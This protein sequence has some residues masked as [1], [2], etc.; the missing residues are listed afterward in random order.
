LNG[1]LYLA[2]Q[3]ENPFHALLSGYLVAKANG[4]LVKLA[5]RFDLDPDTGRVQ[6]IFDNNPQLPF[7]KLHLEFFGGPHGPLTNPGCGTQ[8]VTSV[9]DG[10]NGAS[11][12]RTSQFT[13][14]RNCTVPQFNPTVAMGLQNPAAGSSSAF[15]LRITRSDADSELK[16][17]GTVLPPGLLAKITGVPRCS[18][19]QAAAGACPEGAQI[20]HVE[21]GSGSGPDPFFVQGGKVFLTD[22]YEGAPF[23]LDIAVPAVAGPFDLGL[24][25]VRAA[26][27]IDPTDA[28]ATVTADPMP[29][30]LQGIPLDVRD[31]RVTIDRPGFM[32]APTSCD[33]M[34]IAATLGSYAGDSV[35]VP[36][37]FQVGG[38]GDLPFSPKLAIA[39]GGGKSQ[40]TPGK[41][42]SL[43]ATYTQAAGQANT[44]AVK[45]ALP[46]SLALDPNNSQHVCDH[47]A[48][49]AVHGG[50][51]PC[52]ASTIVGTAT[53]VTPL[54]PN[55]LQAKVYLVQGLRTT[56]T[57]RVVRTLP[58][59]LVPLRGADGVALDLRA[60]S[61]V[62]AKKLVT[63]F[64]QVPDA[65][66]S[67][68]VLD[69][70]GGS[71]GI[72][73]V[74]GNKSL[75]EQGNVANETATAQSGKQIAPGVTLQTPCAKRTRSRVSIKSVKAAGSR[76]LVAG[77]IAR[78]ARNRV[79][80][81]AVCGEV[82]ATRRVKPH[83]G[84]WHATLPLRGRCRKLRVSAV[85]PGGPRHL[86]GRATRVVRTGRW[87]L[88]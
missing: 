22:G 33:P 15:S 56:A 78:N 84:A 46:L 55:P 28:H 16:T 57:G 71:K 43:V 58:T 30:I 6:A 62:V 54:L 13:I 47:D 7:S 19:A 77:R 5:G 74:T 72:L 69:I 44:K 60:Q 45:V 64:S 73:T 42:P 40:T 11:V 10:W 53:A 48:A 80:V 76:L 35:T 83:R 12:Q 1:A 66:V 82:K 14:D 25:N 87:R 81:T 26:L 36:N 29:R 68:F 3:S 52:P 59:L 4:V 50:E 67:K 21:A 9:L 75:C 79:T 23:G 38:C 31:L 2:K 86:R 24:I 85:Y 41:H 51:V 17:V 27:A 8:T 65:P 70:T 34:T 63:T 88:T 39:L 32:Q 20:G 37:R 49:A 18:D 61:A